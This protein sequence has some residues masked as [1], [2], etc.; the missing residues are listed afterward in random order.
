MDE[1][2]D[3]KRYH[4]EPVESKFLAPF[5]DIPYIFDVEYARPSDVFIL[6]G[7]FQNLES[8]E[9]FQFYNDDVIICGFVK[10]GMWESTVTDLRRV[11]N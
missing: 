11:Q 7:Y 6:K 2:K 8:I 3:G 4:G 9:N 10:T 1:E 5:A